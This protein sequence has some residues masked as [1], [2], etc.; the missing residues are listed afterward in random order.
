MLMNR[1]F[2]SHATIAFVAAALSAVSA[3]DNAINQRSIFT[4]QT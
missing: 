1:T 4:P 3:I 2:A